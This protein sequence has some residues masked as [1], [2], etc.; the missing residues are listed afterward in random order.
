MKPENIV[1]HD[2]TKFPKSEF[3]SI[4]LENYYKNLH[5][6]NS[7]KNNTAFN[8]EQFPETSGRVNSNIIPS[9]S[10]QAFPSGVSQEDSFSN[11]PEKTSSNSFSSRCIV[12]IFSNKLLQYKQHNS[13]TNDVV[14]KPIPRLKT[15]KYIEVYTTS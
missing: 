10:L 13:T 8:N 15:A 9:T 12:D 11:D 14:K 3:G 7:E 6:D 1:S 4:D 5:K 2:V